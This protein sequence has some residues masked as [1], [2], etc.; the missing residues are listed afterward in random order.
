M[1]GSNV[2]VMDLIQKALPG[3]IIIVQRLGLPGMEIAAGPVLVEDPQRPVGSVNEYRTCSC[4]RSSRAARRL[5]SA[6][7]TLALEPD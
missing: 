6:S 3:F 2:E 5:P 7:V 1:P 4:R